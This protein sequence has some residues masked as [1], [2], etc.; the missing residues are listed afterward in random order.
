MRTTI[1]S[2]GVIT[3]Q[4]GSGLGIEKDSSNTGFGPFALPVQEITSSLTQSVS[5]AGVISLNIGG[6]EGSTQTMPTAASCPGC[7]FVYRNAGNNET[8]MLT[9]SQETG[10]TKVF[11]DGTSNGS[12]LTIAQ[13][14]PVGGS[15]AFMSD[16]TNFVVLGKSGSITIANA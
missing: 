12:E 1:T 9:G 16:G 8:H 5:D 10:G 11:T 6:G 7:I 15:V 14:T 4:A 2:K 13:S 3:T